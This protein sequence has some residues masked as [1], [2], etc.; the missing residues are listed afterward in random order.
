MSCQ[1]RPPRFV[2]DNKQALYEYAGQAGCRHHGTLAFSRWRALELPSNPSGF[3]SVLEVYD[4][5]YGYEPLPAGSAATEWCVNFADHNLF[6]CCL[7]GLFAQDEIQ[8]A[9]HPVLASL[10]EALGASGSG[11]LTVENGDP[12]PILIRL[13]TDASRG[14]SFPYRTQTPLQRVTSYTRWPTACEQE[15]RSN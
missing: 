9:E 2:D 8:S 10:R 3:R 5:F 7:S 4:G 1:F 11:A 6:G 13:S 14:E 15:I 12:T